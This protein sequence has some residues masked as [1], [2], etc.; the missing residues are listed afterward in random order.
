[1][2]TEPVLPG[3][4]N[5]S[6]R[7][8]AVGGLAALAAGCAAVWYFDP[9]TA[10]I[11]PACPLLVTTGF[12]CPGCGMTRAFHAFF[13]GDV[14]TALDYNALFPLVVIGGVLLVLTLLSV[15]I[16]G[17]GFMRVT[18]WTPAL[19]FG[20]MFLVLGFGVVRNLPSYPFSV[21]FP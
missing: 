5:A 13:H 18:K 4:A 10:G 11:F 15:A 17:R 6:V 2:D 21:L 1:M 12:A 20:V 16:R 3:G 19:L 7:V 8:A 14:L 9:T